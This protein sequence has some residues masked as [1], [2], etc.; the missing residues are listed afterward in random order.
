MIKL[1]VNTQIFFLLIIL[2]DKFWPSL[3]ETVV[4]MPTFYCLCE[5][6]V[7]ITLQSENQT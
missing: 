7:G 3:L 6:C 5:Y 2:L 4:L 1:E